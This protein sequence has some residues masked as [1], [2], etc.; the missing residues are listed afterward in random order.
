LTSFVGKLG[1]RLYT[2]TISPY[3]ADL[4][5]TTHFMIVLCDSLLYP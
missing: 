4:W 1:Y 2:A 3:F 5:S